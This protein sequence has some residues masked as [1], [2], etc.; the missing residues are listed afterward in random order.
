MTL[1]GSPQDK[2]DRL[3]ARGGLH[4]HPEQVQDALFHESDFFDPR[5]LAQVRYEMLRRHVVEGRP[6]TEI[7]RSFGVSRQLFYVVT[8]LF[9]QQGFW[10]LLPKKRGPQAAS[11]CSEELLSYVD[12]RR[13]EN[14][15]YTLRQLIDE[16]EAKFDIHLHRRTLER[17][18]ARREKKRHRR[19]DSR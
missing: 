5:D 2:R 8:R 9:Q 14:P 15:Q 3:A 11:K 6:V 18:L 10:G 12:Q 19:R 17:G 13:A 1:P 7:V 4:P 16:I